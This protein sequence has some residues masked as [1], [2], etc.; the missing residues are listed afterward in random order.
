[1]RSRKSLLSLAIIAGLTLSTTP[2][3]AKPK[4]TL[5]EIEAAKQAEAVKKAAADA[6]AKKLAAANATLKQLTAKSNAARALYKKAQQELAIATSQA[7]AAAQ[8]AAET[9]AAVQ[10]AH[11]IIGK[12]AAN[13]YILGG[14]MSDIQ[15]LLSS[16]GPQE[17]VDQLSTLNTLGARNTTALERYKAAEIVA[18]A[19]KQRADDAK[20][21]QVTATA[22]V[23][24][25]KKV[26]DDAQALQQQEVNK[27]QA[28]QNQLMKELASARNVR[29]TLEQQRQLALLEENQATIATTTINQAKVWP[30]IGFKGR[31]TVRTTEAQRLI[32]VAFAKKQVLARKPYV[33]GAQG[34]NS[35]DCS[36]LVYAAYKAAGLDWP[37]WD[38]LNAAL[39]AGYTKHVSLTELAPGDLLFYSYKGTISTIHHITIY[40]GGG[41][42]WEANSTKTGLIYSSIYSVKGL[43][44]FGGRV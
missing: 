9:A 44:P 39:Y 40:A 11:R 41:M 5:A 16:N 23:A 28:V 26:A 17:L 2:A 42:M 24:A 1:V 4:P 27:L 8:H 6:A 22:K 30:D 38:R 15:P 25:A 3:L 7:V 33:W 20:A 12:L 36:G 10:Q 34:P 37:N 35:F 32:A 29:V 18:K 31:T 14:N 19:A 21:L 43:M 13:A